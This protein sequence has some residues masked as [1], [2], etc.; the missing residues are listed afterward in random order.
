MHTMSRNI[1]SLLVTVEY[2]NLCT[3]I[4]KKNILMH[5]HVSCSHVRV[6]KKHSECQHLEF[7][8]LS[9]L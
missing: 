4:P 5:I 3:L 1:K 7:K 9:G 2:I 8:L 6:L